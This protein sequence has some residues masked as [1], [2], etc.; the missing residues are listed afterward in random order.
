MRRRWRLAGTIRSFDHEHGAIEFG[1]VTSA[2]VFTVTSHDETVAGQREQ[3]QLNDHVR[4][5]AKANF[6]ALLCAAQSSDGVCHRGSVAAV[7]VREPWPRGSIARRQPR[8]A[9]Y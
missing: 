7:I 6:Q 2:A 1:E 9:T 8:L 4:V 5:R 3:P